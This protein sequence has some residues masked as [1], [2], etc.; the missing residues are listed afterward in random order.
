LTEKFET[1]VRM[2]PQFAPREGRAVDNPWGRDETDLTE[3]L[4]GN[5]GNG[6]GLV[7]PVASS[8]RRIS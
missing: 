1:D 3:T 2:L 8:V 4:L 6:S 5:L 7:E